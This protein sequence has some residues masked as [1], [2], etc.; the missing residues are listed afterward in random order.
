MTGVEAF[1]YFT[2]GFGVGEGDAGRLG[3]FTNLASYSVGSSFF[4]SVLKTFFGA[5]FNSS[6]FWCSTFWDL[7]TYYFWTDFDFCAD[8][9][10][11]EAAFYLFFT[12]IMNGYLTSASFGGSMTSTGYSSSA[13]AVFL[14]GVF[15]ASDFDRY[16]GS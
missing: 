7:K 14:L 1:F 6:G 4:D 16:D 2:A 15:F 12:T 8:E 13:I 11:G 5:G 10:I 9:T 3:L